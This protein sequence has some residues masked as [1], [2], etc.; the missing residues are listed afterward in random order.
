MKQYQQQASLSDETKRCTIRLIVA[1]LLLWFC[2]HS[3]VLLSQI[4]IVSS[5]SKCVLIR[6]SNTVP[7]PVQEWLYYYDQFIYPPE[8]HCRVSNESVHM[9]SIPVSQRL[10]ETYQIELICIEFLGFNLLSTCTVPYTPWL[11]DVNLTTKNIGFHLSWNENV[12]FP[13]NFSTPEEN[14]DQFCAES[15]QSSMPWYYK[16]IKPIP[17][18]TLLLVNMIGII[19]ISIAMFMYVLRL[20]MQST[21]YATKNVKRRLSSAM[22]AVSP[23]KVQKLDSKVN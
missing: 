11:T 4:C 16:Y 3:Y 20:C 23:T 7:P 9:F 8:Q 6:W 12:E 18:S 15:L 21:T 1:S 10:N 13:F 5:D 19:L 22:I 14:I 17:S 2:F